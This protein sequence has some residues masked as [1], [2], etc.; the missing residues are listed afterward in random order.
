[1]MRRGE[2]LWPLGR[3]AL[4]YVETHLVDHCNM[5]C[6]GCSHFSPLADPWFA[7]PETFRNDLE[8]LARLFRS[9]RTIRLMGGEPLLHPRVCDFLPIAR[10][11]FPRAHIQLVTNGLL[12]AKMP[13]DFWTACRAN[14]I[15]LSIT[16]Y[17]P[18]RE[19]IGVCTE[20]CRKEGV[21]CRVTPADQFCVWLNGKGDSPVAES[22]ARCRKSLYC[23]VLKDGALYTCATA[24]YIDVFNCRF[25][26]RLPASVGLNVHAKGLTGHSAL[27]VLNRS[28]ELCRY[29]AIEKGV[30]TWSNSA[31]TAAD[32][33]V[34]GTA[35]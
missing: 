29:C 26:L 18:M 17:P 3:P 21:S 35:Q 15:A 23:P 30:M 20:K 33:F 5:N 8:A 24:A 25:G 27:N 28:I 22:F 31:S 11:C 32:W 4:E 10:K 1:M 2:L 9:V 13:D 16:L 12:L 6:R 19:R 34:R 14:R 7:E